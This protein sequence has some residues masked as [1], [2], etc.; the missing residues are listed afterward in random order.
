MW[1]QI[2]GASRY[3]VNEKGQIKSTTRGRETMLKPHKANNNCMMVNIYFDDKSHRYMT[4]HRI[5][6]NAFIPNPYDLPQ[7]NHKDENREN[8]SVANLEWCN[9][10]YNSNYGTGHARQTMM[11]SKPVIQKKIDGEVVAYYP[12]TIE[13]QRQTGIQNGN[14]SAVC[15]KDKWRHTA[16]G[17]LWE[18]VD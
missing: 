17:Y 15:R 9:G 12:S 4:V 7:V 13:A 1:K 14:I 5:V 6:A 18:Y 10:K 2:E 8:N 16:G 3:F 11:C